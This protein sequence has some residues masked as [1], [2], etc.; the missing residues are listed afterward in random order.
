MALWIPLLVVY[1]PS[2]T[3]P[4]A[5]SK[6]TNLSVPGRDFGKGFLSD[7]HENSPYFEIKN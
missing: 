5:P 6:P 2:S 7:M 4:K 1:I 3:T